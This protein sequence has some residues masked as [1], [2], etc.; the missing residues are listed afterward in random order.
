MSNRPPEKRVPVTMARVSPQLE[1]KIN[2]LAKCEGKLKAISVP[3]GSSRAD[4][5]LKAQEAFR[6]YGELEMRV[7]DRGG[8]LL[9]EETARAGWVCEI[10]KKSRKKSEIREGEK[11]KVM[12]S[13]NGGRKEKVEVSKKI[14]EQ[15]MID[16][17]RKRFSVKGETV[18]LS[19]VD[20]SGISQRG[21][22]VYE[23]FRFELRTHR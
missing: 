3:E 4:V 14:G 16:L 13:A 23:G 11:V 21:F 12:V 5:Q 6:V 20:R 17:I 22:S 10:S 8:I 2:V 18:G 9:H 7:E 19:I 15:E 1:K